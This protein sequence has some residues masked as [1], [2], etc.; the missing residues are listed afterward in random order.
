MFGDAV[1]QAR[2]RMGAALA[3]ERPANADIVVPVP[4]SGLF[5]ALGYARE[6]GLPLEF[7]LIRNHYVG[8]T[9]I[10]PSQY[11][12]TLH[13]DLKLN[14]VRWIVAGKRAITRLIAGVPRVPT[15]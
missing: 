12:R 14:V 4:D 15:E 13:A 6:S 9:F 11:V 1:S 5:S 7:G 3:R 10:Q 8:R 2:L